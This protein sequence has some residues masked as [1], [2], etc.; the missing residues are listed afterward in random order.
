M[1]Q[2]AAGITKKVGTVRMAKSLGL[3]ISRSMLQ[4]EWRG[5]RPIALAFDAVRLHG[6]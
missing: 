6:T 4:S 3:G 1:E 5:Q 2:L